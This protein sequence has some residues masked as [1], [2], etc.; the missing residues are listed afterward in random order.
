MPRVTRWEKTRSLFSIVHTPP[1]VMRSG[2]MPQASIYRRLHSQRST[3][4]LPFPSSVTNASLSGSAR[5][6]AAQGSSTSKL[7]FEIDGPTAASRSAGSVPNSAC[8]FSIV[9]FAMPFTV[10][11]QPACERPIARRFGS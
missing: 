4:N 6:S 8:I 10:P 1:T 3:W 5:N 9:A 11:R 7:R 2:R